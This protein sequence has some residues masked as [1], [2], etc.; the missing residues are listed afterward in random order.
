VVGSKHVALAAA[1]ALLCLALVD[2]GSTDCAATLTCDAPANGGGGA[3]G[4]GTAG[5]G[6]GGAGKPNGV[7]CGTGDE[8]TSGLCVDSVC[9]AAECDG[10]C[11][12]CDVSGHEGECTPHPAATDPDD[13]CDPGVCDG[14]G[15]CATGSEAWLLPFE[16]D[17]DSIDMAVDSTGAVIIAAV[18]CCGHLT[19]DGVD[20]AGVGGG[21]SI[22]LIKL[23]P[24]KSVA[25]SHAYAESGTDYLGHVEVAVDASDNI[26]VVGF[27]DLAVDFGGTPTGATDFFAVLFD[28]AGVEQWTRTF[29]T[30][31]G[32]VGPTIRDM[33]VDAAGNIYV[34]G[35]LRGSVTICGDTWSPAMS[36]QPDLFAYKLDAAGTCVWFDQWAA[37]ATIQAAATDGEGLYLTGS[38]SG[39]LNFGNKQLST[40]GDIDIFLAGLD[41]GSG[42]AEWS[43]Q[44]GDA[45]GQGGSALT[46]HASGDLLFAATA[47]GMFDL[48]GDLLMGSNNDDLVLALFSP[49]GGHHD[50]RIYGDGTPQHARAIA[51]GAQ[52]EIYVAG[53]NAGTIAF[54]DVTL[55]GA[56]PF[57]AA[58]ATLEEGLWAY[59]NDDFGT[60]SAAQTLAVDGDGN[61]FT[62]VE[63]MN[64]AYV[65]KRAP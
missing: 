13:E 59:S 12:A 29:N 48:G 40:D 35:S 46:M 33:V 9:C 52:G 44:F 50:S 18:A 10:I 47:G 20:L 55:A 8:C 28:P 62:L 60:A 7:G 11:E 30:T 64:A 23:N 56:G 43:H 25:W 36:S 57:T 17:I 37:T 1:A 2:C 14:F 39:P 4:G 21:E 24:D 5:D 3:G 51:A 27:T 45:L 42:D 22:Y 6:G 19:V 58:L 16:G 54:G 49:G 26:V 38:F 34:I 32:I 53:D 41:A 65:S 15:S 31:G 63:A 61:V